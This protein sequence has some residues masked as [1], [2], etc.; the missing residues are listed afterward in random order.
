MKP[1]WDLFGLPK[2]VKVRGGC[3][4]GLK[5]SGYFQGV[6]TGQGEPGRGGGSIQGNKVM[7]FED[8]P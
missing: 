3:T 6:Y 5:G 1:G 4:R 2:T 8:T 7:L